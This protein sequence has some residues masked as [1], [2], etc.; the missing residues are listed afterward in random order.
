MGFIMG[1]LMYRLSC[2]EL[3]LS[4]AFSDAL[5]FLY[6]DL[7]LILDSSSASV[8]SFLVSQALQ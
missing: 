2:F 8:A 6:V 1:S 7:N 3:M 5:T 4:E